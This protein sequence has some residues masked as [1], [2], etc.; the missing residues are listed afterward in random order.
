MPLLVPVPHVPQARPRGWPRPLRNLLV[1]LVALI[2]AFAA[3]A[4]PPGRAGRLGY[5]SGQVSFSPA[6]EDD[7]AGAAINRPLTTGDRLWAD[8]DG[9][10]EVQIGQATMRMGAQTGVTVLNL[11]DQTA[12]I[13]LSQG[14][15]QL[16]VRRLDPEETIEIATPILALSVRQPGEYR[17]DVPAEGDSATVR[18]R[19]GAADVSG[20]GASYALRAGEAWRFRGAALADPESLSPPPD[21]DFDVWVVERQRRADTS[22]SARYVS[23]ELVGYQ[24]LDDNGRWETD[25]AYGR[26]W[27]PVKVSVDWAPYRDGHWAWVE[28]WGW[29]WVDD[30]PWGYAV[31]HYGRWA[32]SRGRWVWVPGPPRVR[33][34]YAPA[35]VAFVG[36]PGLK[37]TI[38]AGPVT[39]VA[40]FP[41]GPREV[42][43]P[44]YNASPR[45]F[46]RVNTSN[47]VIRQ[48]NI[49]KVYQNVNVT[50]VY[51]N[52]KVKGAVVA[53]PSDA[54]VKSQSVTKTRVQ[55]SDDVIVKQKVTTTV[56]VAPVKASLAVSD[57]PGRRPPAQVTTRTVVVKKAPPPPKP[58]FAVKAAALERQPGKPLDDKE[59]AELRPAANRD[60]AA[61][62]PRV[63]VVQAT[64][65]KAPPQRDKDGNRR[66]DGAAKPRDRD[67]AADRQQG[68]AQRAGRDGQPEDRAGRNGAA[69]R[70]ASASSPARSAS[71]ADRDRPAR[72]NDDR[73]DRPRDAAKPPQRA[74]SAPRDGGARRDREDGAAG[75]VARPD[76][77]RDGARSADPAE[78]PASRPAAR[79]GD[80]PPRAN[81]DGEADRP[82]RASQAGDDGERRPPQPARARPEPRVPGEPRESAA[83]RE[84]ADRPARAASQA[85]ERRPPR[86]ARR[87]EQAASP[88]EPAPTGR[89]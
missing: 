23:R 77:E 55:V 71:A 4:D 62:A 44:A 52:R 51:V 35:L 22:V 63:K 20:E 25:P 7:W 10:A 86:A 74:A 58:A 34:V 16:R 28:P 70:P 30:A 27:T 49:T 69:E 79:D 39:G 13:E 85:D 8:A 48:V 45:Y 31:S 61:P 12:Q 75:A 33:P 56:Q 2:A 1:A 64:T 87:P 59:V 78:R 18:V 84:G 38:N 36:G 47:T 89:P 21:D 88:P 60:S 68:D 14:T 43:R 76:R 26:V 57:R 50:Q 9:R 65:P 53:V 37:L 29:T 83:L 73:A 81:R 11:D 15:L 19:S 82:R 17:I 67:G 54:F 40:W 42:Y 5:L 66:D 46:E 72:A 3:A 24:D 6:G 80:R 32:H 41:L